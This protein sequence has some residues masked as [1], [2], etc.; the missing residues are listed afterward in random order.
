MNK[1]IIITGYCATG[2]STFS[3][4]L[5]E[6][7]KIPC[8]NKDT[9]KEAMGDGLGSDN[10]LVFQKGSIA[11]FKIMLHI[12]EQFLHIGKICILESNF[13]TYEI[14]EVKALLDKYNSQCLTYLF[15]GDFNIIYDRYRNR[16]NIGE[17]HWVHQMAGET[18]ES[19]ETGHKKSGMGEKGIGKIVDIDAA[20]FEKINFEELILSAKDYVIN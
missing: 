19:F 18:K 17:R 7:L 6:E 3:R 15:K 14:D 8:F 4:K 16:D 12:A 5:S 1:I 10:N 9:L 2:K 13:K 11:T 20:Y